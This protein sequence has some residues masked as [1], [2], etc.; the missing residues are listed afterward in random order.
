MEDLSGI[1]VNPY[2][3]PQEIPGDNSAFDDF[4]DKTIKKLQDQNALL[5]RAIE[6]NMLKHSLRVSQ[7]KEEIDQLRFRN[8]LLNTKIE[9]MNR[10]N[11]END[12][13]CT[14]S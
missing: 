9:R 2:L 1:L 7:M 10:N 3:Q 4:K 13:K 11:D 12:G 5:T 14:I 8:V 6:E